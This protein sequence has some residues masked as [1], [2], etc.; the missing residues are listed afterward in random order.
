M[1]HFFCHIT[2]VLWLSLSLI[3]SLV[4]FFF[5]FFFFFFSI[6][7]YICRYMYMYCFVCFVLLVADVVVYFSVV[8]LWSFR[9]YSLINLFQLQSPYRP[10]KSGSRAV[11]SVVEVNV[12]ESHCKI[13]LLK[14][15]ALKRNIKQT[16]KT[17]KKKK[18][19]RKEKKRKEKKRKKKIF[20]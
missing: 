13:C 2:W 17:K 6:Y 19:K 1:K 11:R 9:H 5:L 8:F 16:N 7:V 10:S 4:F 15:R 18:K 12:C 20:F 3:L 14:N